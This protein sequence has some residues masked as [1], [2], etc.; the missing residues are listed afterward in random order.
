MLYLSHCP[1]TKSSTTVLFFL[2][3]VIRKPLMCQISK[4]LLEKKYN[5]HFT[6]GFLSIVFTSRS[7]IFQSNKVLHLTTLEQSMMPKTN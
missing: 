1:E 3:R 2:Q 7:G 4:L 6:F 5:F